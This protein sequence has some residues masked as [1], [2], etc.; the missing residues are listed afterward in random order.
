M[1]RLGRRE[2]AEALRDRIVTGLHVGRYA[3]GERL[4]GAASLAR[5]FHVNERVVLA[6]LRRLA[7]DGFVVVKRRSGSYVAIPHAASR[8]NLPDLGAWIVRVAAEG[9]A[10]GVSPR[11]LSDLIHSR[12]S[13]R[14]IRAACIECNRDQLHLLCTELSSDYGF[15]TDSVEVD[16]I[17]R[18]TL[19]K[20]VARAD[21]LITT[22]Y[23]AAEVRAIAER[24]SKPWKAVTLRPDVIQEVRSRLRTGPVYY[25]A[26]DARFEPKL[27]QMIGA[28]SR[29]SNLRLLL[30]NKH[31]LDVIPADAPTYVMTSARE[32]VSRTYGSRGGPGEQFQPP[33]HFSNEAAQDILSFVVQ[34]NLE[35]AQRQ[36]KS[37]SG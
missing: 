36:R 2:V 23:H 37:S 4:P 30:V 27:R 19:P 21:V 15:K 1:K 14:S 5:E 31:D 12:L 24:L 25:I 26:V 16:E 13:R 20:A 18:E 10:R 8:D 3:G 7:E 28:K 34:T 35:E 33:R 6:A 29:L 32:H 9:R 22:M 17:R 11:S